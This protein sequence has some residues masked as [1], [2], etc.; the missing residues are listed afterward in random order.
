[1]DVWYAN[2]DEISNERIIYDV[3]SPDEISEGKRFRTQHLRGRYYC[4]KYIIRLLAGKYLNKP[5]HSITILKTA[6]GKPY[7]GDNHILHFNASHSSNMFVVTFSDSPVGIDIEFMREL[8][9]FAGVALNVCSEDE[10][11]YFNQLSGHD[12]RR[13]FF[14]LWSVKESFLKFTGFG[15]LKDPRDVTIADH[16]NFLENDI[17][18]VISDGTVAYCTSIDFGD[19]DFF[20]FVCSQRAGDPVALRGVLQENVLG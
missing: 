6:E 16:D 18:K 13:Y 11:I 20:C 19:S 8:P 10:Y 14:K 4:T 17:V 2:L 5:A 1:M 12:Q 9:D 7:L 3:L 15:L